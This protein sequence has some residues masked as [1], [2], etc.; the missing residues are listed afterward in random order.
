MWKNPLFFDFWTTRM[1][2]FTESDNAELRET[3]IIAQTL[4]TKKHFCVIISADS[5]TALPSGAEIF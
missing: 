2:P 3:D 5:R 4:F 1:L